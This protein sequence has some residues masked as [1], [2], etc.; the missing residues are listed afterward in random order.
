VLLGRHVG[1]VGEAPSPASTF[2]PTPRVV[3]S[4]TRLTKWRRSR[5]RRRVSR[6][7]GIAGAKRLE[8]GG[9]SWPVVTAPGC[10]VLVKM[11]GGHADGEKRIALKIEHL[12]A[13]A[14]ETRM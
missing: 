1:D 6:R 3:R 5:P 12:G 9:E 8:T 2:N 10:Q 7:S 14:F 13:V 4:C 11:R